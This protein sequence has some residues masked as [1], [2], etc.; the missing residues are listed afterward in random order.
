MKLLTC[1]E[2]AFELNRNVS[3]V[4]AMRS[5]GFKMPAGRA[6]ISDAV[7]WLSHNPEFRRDHARDAK[8][9]IAEK[10]G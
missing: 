1:K 9:Q 3:Y 4:Y 5:A 6:T 8:P 7:T 10:V 2:L